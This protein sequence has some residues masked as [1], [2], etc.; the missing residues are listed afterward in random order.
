PEL[1]AILPVDLKRK[2]TEKTEGIFGVA[3]DIGTSTIAAYLLDLRTGQ[4][5]S[6][7]SMVN[8]QI[9]IGA[10]VI[11]RIRYA[12][13]SADGAQLLNQILID[14]I[15]GLITSLC[16][17][18]N[19]SPQSIFELVA[20]GNT[21]M[22]HN[23]LSLPVNQLGSAP[24]VPAFN[25][26]YYTQASELGLNMIGN[27]KIYVGPIVAGFL[28]ADA[29]GN[30]LITNMLGNSNDFSPDGQVKLVIDIG[31]NSE[32]LLCDQHRLIACSAAAGPAFEGGNLQFGIRACPGAVYSISVSRGRVSYSTMDG[33]RACG[34]TGSGVVEG[35]GEFLRVGAIRDSGSIDRDTYKGW[36]KY[37]KRIKLHRDKEP[38]PSCDLVLP[39]LKIVPRTKSALDSTI[40]IT[41]N[42]I[43]EI[44]LAKAAIRTGIDILMAELGVTTDDL[45]VVYLAG[46]FGNYLKPRSAV[47]INLIPDIELEKIKSIGNAAGSSAKIL[48]RSRAARDFVK[49]IAN[50]IEY[51]D[52][53]MHQK[54]QDL[55]IK[56]ME[57]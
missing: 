50:K 22:L 27:G 6:V 47:E 1:L 24:Y 52:L 28:G 42:D 14:A 55:F 40:T 21:T 44:Q 30:A 3:I 2:S 5:C 10:D 49:H 19:I 18:S 36:L 51:I 12:K 35:I 25:G 37:P 8:P 20:V 43:R 38:T 31:T 32:L 45:D 16:E 57:F 9:R 15:N 56:N 4:E 7:A 34:I 48:L 13:Q 17:D 29:V 54:F 33:R 39:E 11:S 46:A 26:N 41:Q 23:F 53:A